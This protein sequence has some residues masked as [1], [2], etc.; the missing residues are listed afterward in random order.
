MDESRRRSWVLPVVLLGIAYA[1]VGI[2]FAVPTT[3]AHAWR[4]A[5][6]AVCAVGYGAHILYERFRLGNSSGTAALHVALAAGLG[7]FGLAVGANVHELFVEAT[8]QHQRLLLLSLGIWPIV[9]AL[10][11]FVVAL[12]V[13][14]VLPRSRREMGGSR[15]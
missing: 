8:S 12:V 9:T 13:N 4:L 3:H 5:A 15:S 6:W 10:P 11:A 14:L 1:G 7:G 2:L